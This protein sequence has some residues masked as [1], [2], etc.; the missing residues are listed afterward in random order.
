MFPYQRTALLLRVH[1]D[2][3]IP[4]EI[5]NQLKPMEM[6]MIP[7]NPDLGDESEIGGVHISPHTVFESCV[8][9]GSFFSIRSRSL[10][11]FVQIPFIGKLVMW[12]RQHFFVRRYAKFLS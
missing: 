8:F 12:A 1:E 6:K 11:F 7:S 10:F 2:T 9:V 3:G 4:V 5:N